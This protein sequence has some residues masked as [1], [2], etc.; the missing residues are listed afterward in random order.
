MTEKTSRKAAEAAKRRLLDITPL[1]EATR[2]LH[3]CARILPLR[4]G[5]FA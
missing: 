5:V 4:L 3:L 2:Y 1:N